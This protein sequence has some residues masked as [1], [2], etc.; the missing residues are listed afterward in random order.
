MNKHTKNKL[1]TP[2]YFLKRLKDNQFTTFRIF[3]NYS[4]AD[5]RKWTVLVDPGGA[6][7][8]I[9]CYENKNFSGEVLFEFADGNQLFNRNIFIKTDS[10]EVIVTMLLEAGVQQREEPPVVV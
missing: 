1:S 7:I 10:I 6:S 5:P 4:A 9:T 3:Q 2:G 8:Y